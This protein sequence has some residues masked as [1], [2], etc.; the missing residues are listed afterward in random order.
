[1]VGTAPARRDHPLIPSEP[2][3]AVMSLD[4]LEELYLTA[5]T[6]S[7]CAAGIGTV[8]WLRAG[9]YRRPGEIRPLPGH[10]WVAAVVPAAGVLVALALADQPWPV[11]LPYLLLVPTGAALAAIDAD[12]ERL[13]NMITL[14]LI[15]IQLGLLLAATI[16]TD[17]W[18]SMLRALLALAMIGSLSL[19]AVLL[20]GF[21]LGDFKLMLTLAPCLGWLGWDQLLIG[22]SAGFT[23]GALWAMGLVVTK[24]A[25]RR[26]YMAFGPFLVAGTL[27][28]LA[29]G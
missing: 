23:L 28:T 9:A 8:T 25:S 19:M 15:P 18:P 22:L 2:S 16:V 7:M 24:R 26:S 6:V 27:L 17:A 21:G 4:D 5:V 1:M 14:P 12:V 10:L 29:I 20:R 3:E 13:P 11:L